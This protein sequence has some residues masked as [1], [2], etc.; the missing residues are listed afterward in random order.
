MSTRH[1]AEQAVAY[2]TAELSDAERGAVDAHIAN[3]TACRTELEHVRVALGALARW[4]REPALD[5]ATEARIL[6]KLRET[7]SLAG[8]TTGRIQNRWWQSRVA[9]A[10]ALGFASGVLGFGFGRATSGPESVSG[11]ATTAVA[12][13]SSLRSYLLLLEEPVWPP[14]RPLSRTGYGDWIRAIA[15]EDRYVGAEKL[16]EEPG[17]RVSSGGGVARPERSTAPPNVSG[18][19]VIRAVSYDEAIAWARRGP[20]LAHGTVLVRQIEPTPRTVR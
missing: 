9:A 1:V 15:A 10:I 20:H 12:A 4:P 5:P 2:W 3:C 16:T 18:W 19:Y 13:D 6:A 17:F 7:A 11:G 14:A 8:S